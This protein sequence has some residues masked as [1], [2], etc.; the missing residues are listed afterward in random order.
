M[1]CEKNVK[2][3]I[4]RSSWV[5]PS[6]GSDRGAHSGWGPRCIQS[7]RS[8]RCPVLLLQVPGLCESKKTWPSDNADHD[9][10]AEVY[11]WPQGCTERP[12]HASAP[13]QEE[14]GQRAEVR[15]ICFTDDIKSVNMTASGLN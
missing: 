2:D 12:E 5:Y 8:G 9:R 7:I 6:Q 11:L 10:S 15:L 4:Q 1:K 3:P 13:A 14:K